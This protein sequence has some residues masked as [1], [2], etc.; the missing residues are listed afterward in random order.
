MEQATQPSLPLPGRLPSGELDLT[1]RTLADFRVLRHL[2]QGGMGQVYLAEQIS[3]KRK[4][5]LKI[6]RPE[7][8]ADP[9]A[10][11]R[12][13]AEATAV[14]QATHANIVQI[15][16]IGEADGIT[17]MALEYVEGRNLHE[18]VLRKGPPDLLLALSIMRQVAAALQ[19]A[20]ELG[21]I[22]RDI[23]PENILLTRKGEVKV[24]D[25][26]LSRCL[27]GDR[28]AVHLT[29]SGV[30]MGTPLYMS[31]EQVEGKTLDGRTDIYS[32]GVTCYH[33][34]AGQP[35]FRGESAF[36]VALQH[37]RDLPKPLTEVRPDLPAVLCAIV[38]KM[39]AKDPA[40]RYQTGRELLKDIARLREGLSGATAAVPSSQLSVELVP[41]SSPEITEAA[42][43]G[44]AAPTIKT[45]PQAPVRRRWRSLVVAVSVLLAAG[46]G[47]GAGWI[48][49][50]LS[51][52]AQAAVVPP[53]EETKPA[54]P[55]QDEEKALRLV[56]EPYL[57]S[58]LAGIEVQAGL[59]LCMKLGAFYLEHD[60]LDDAREF[61]ARLEKH[62]RPVYQQLG[63]VGR[64]IVLALRNK[65]K[66]SN[67]LLRRVVPRRPQQAGRPIWDWMW[68]EEQWRYW[69]RKALHYNH[70]NGIKDKDVPE[71]LHKLL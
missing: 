15:H 19:R 57:H 63:H 45:G 29:Q 42:G 7:M 25:F 47:I 43:T 44:A 64:A 14:A 66:E 46:L 55:D 69:V 60:R 11:P 33:M 40:Q 26:G 54:T 12:F 23:K 22:H 4:V 70:Q 36:E 50:R 71:P 9:T 2:G 10:L 56:V 6:L 31:P 18:Y 16:A 67:E 37:V 34:L 21:I 61:F 1:G 41:L 20:G 17:Y 62:T 59:N 8:A 58:H 35:P 38:H 28:P 30:T 24:A 39:M 49:H 3:L 51:A 53:I 65:A 32:F 48:H 27:D 68:Q 13:K 52:P 5:A